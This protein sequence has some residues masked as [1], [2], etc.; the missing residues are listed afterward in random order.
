MCDEKKDMEELP[1]LTSPAKPS[2]SVTATVAN[3][4][5]EE[6]Q[7]NLNKFIFFKLHLS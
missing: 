5:D 4:E 3:K 6:L 2:G 1:C 7:V